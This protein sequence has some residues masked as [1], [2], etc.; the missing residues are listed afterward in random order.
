MF[1]NTS[2]EKP[3]EPWQKVRMDLFQLKGK[4]YLLLIDHHSNYPEFC[5]LSSTMAEHA[6][7]PRSHNVGL[8]L[9]S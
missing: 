5:Q 3:E 2:T 1:A 6:Q 7:R 9:Q 4:D 8:L